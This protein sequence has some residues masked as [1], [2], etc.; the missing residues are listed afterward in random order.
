MVERISKEVEILGHVQNYDWGIIGD[1]SLVAQLHKQNC[2]IAGDESR[3][4]AE[5]WM[6]THPSGPSVVKTQ[7]QTLRDYLSN[8][9][10]FL[11]KVLSV[12]KALSI[13]AHPNRELAEQLH[14]T[15]P[16]HYKD[17]NHK[18]EMAIALT[19]FEALCGFRP[20]KEIS[21]FADR[22]PP[23]QMLIGSGIIDSNEELKRAFSMLMNQDSE[24]VQH[25]ISQMPSSGDELIS[26]FHRLNSQ[27]PGDVGVFCVFFLHNVCLEPGQAIFL[28]ANEPHAYL[29]GSCVECMAT[30]DNVVRAGLTPKYRDVSTLCEM[31]TYRQ[32]QSV[33]ELLMPAAKIHPFAWLYESPVPEFS[34][35]KVELPAGQWEK[36][37]VSGQSIILC[38]TGSARLTTEA[39]VFDVRPG[40]II[41]LPANVCYK[42]A[43]SS[44]S[45]LLYQAFEPCQ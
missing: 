7:Q 12:G 19:S 26:L 23:L 5:L 34:V 28:A 31:L 9:L 38:V 20:V 35:V 42:V 4:Y 25:A 1:A 17:A 13:Q 21:A 27:Y 16:Q 29:S 30:S 10:P 14:R 44:S 32:F 45:C 8:D 24:S 3:P 40:S 2:G 36:M 15:Q 41:Y 11:F 6:G 37:N 18:P 43:T 39:A 22:Y 33:D